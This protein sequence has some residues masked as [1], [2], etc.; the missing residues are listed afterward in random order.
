MAR[1]IRFCGD[2]T[3]TRSTHQ[4]YK[5]SNSHSNSSWSSNLPPPPQKL[6]WRSSLKPHSHLN[7][8]L[9]Y[10]EIYFDLK[11][12]VGQA[13][14]TRTWFGAHLNPSP[15]QLQSEPSSKSA[16]HSEPCGMSG[17]FDYSAAGQLASCRPREVITSAHA[18][19]GV[20]S[21]VPTFFSHGTYSL[22]IPE[23]FLL[24]A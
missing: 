12:L 21:S 1:F 19:W 14:R 6:T 13:S 24:S 9:I 10:F 3:R 11:L 2:P 8:G 16:D 20:P 17:G 23:S 15:K 4:E 7:P 5:M 18:C 22:I